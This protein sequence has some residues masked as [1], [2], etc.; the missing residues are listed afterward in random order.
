ME[1]SRLDNTKQ[2]RTNTGQF[3]R[4]GIT[5]TNVTKNKAKS[6]D[7]IISEFKAKDGKM[8]R[9]QFLTY[10]M[11]GEKEIHLIYKMKEGHIKKKF[12]KHGDIL[13][14]PFGYVK[15]LNTH[16][17]TKRE[18]AAMALLDEDGN[19]RKYREEDDEQHYY[20]RVLDPLSAEE[21][22][23]LEPINLA[24]VREIR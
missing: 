21:L 13:E 17:K 3:K 23:E 10:G 9:G 8:I 18:G 15:Y 6:K 2:N 20:F 5:N 14:L 19:P 16:G 12:V 7:T 22:S 1:Q 24:S 11:K 4:G